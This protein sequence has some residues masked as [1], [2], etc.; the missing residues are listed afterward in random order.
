MSIKKA[1][2]RLPHMAILLLVLLAASSCAGPA[3]V[4]PTGRSTPQ[5]TA[6]ARTP[7]PESAPP[8]S[9]APAPAVPAPQ[10]QVPEPRQEP[11]PRTIASLRLTDQA[12]S[13]LDAG[14]PDQAIRTLERA[15]NLN[16]SSGENFYYLSEAWLMKGNLRQAQEFNRLAALH[17]K[18]DAVWMGRVA[19]QAERIKKGRPNPP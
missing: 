13:F 2:S 10:D 19:A 12:R 5:A 1:T 9:Q 7:P 18:N 16:P 15:I 17:L 3:V 6:P 8:P 14:K 11:T 4:R